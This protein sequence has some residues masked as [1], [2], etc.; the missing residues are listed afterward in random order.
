V[1]GRRSAA[2]RNETHA[3]GFSGALGPGQRGSAG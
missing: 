1:I 3:I 2:D